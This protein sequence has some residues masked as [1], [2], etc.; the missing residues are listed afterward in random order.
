MEEFLENITPASN[1]ML[2]YLDNKDV[3]NLSCTS[4]KVNNYLPSYFSSN[5]D[6]NLYYDYWI[7][8]IY[9]YIFKLCKCNT[10]YSH[11]LNIKICSEH[12]CLTINGRDY[13]SIFGYIKINDKRLKDFK[14][15]LT[16]QYDDYSDEF[17]IHPVTFS[18]DEDTFYSQIISYP[19]FDYKYKINFNEVSCIHLSIID[20]QILKLFELAED[21]FTPDKTLLLK[22]LYKLSLFN[23]KEIKSE[24]II[25]DFI[26]TYTLDVPNSLLHLFYKKESSQ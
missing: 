3:I 5:I 14:K 18:L 4:K 2:S 17:T 9:Y 20:R 19:Y 15:Y 23:I 13:E 10:L 6:L 12:D 21:I 26:N 7:H 8:C 16:Y 24:S 1:N 11:E 22:F 25:Y